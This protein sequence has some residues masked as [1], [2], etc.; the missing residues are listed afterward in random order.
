MLSHVGH[1]VLNL[2]SEEARYKY[3]IEHRWKDFQIMGKEIDWAPVPIVDED[4]PARF[5][6]GKKRF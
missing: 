5:G 6:D 4:L 3:D 1:I 2:F